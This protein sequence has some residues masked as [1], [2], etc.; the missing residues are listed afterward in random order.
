MAA[1]RFDAAGVPVAQV[2]R[3]PSLITDDRLRR[4]VEECLAQDKDYSPHM[5]RVR[6]GL[7]AEY[8]FIL[9]QKLR[10]RRVYEATSVCAAPCV[11]D[12]APLFGRALSGL[13]SISS[14]SS[15]RLHIGWRGV[16][17]SFTRLHKAFCVFACDRCVCGS[18]GVLVNKN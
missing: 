14:I 7:G 15:C 11:V 8:E 3:S 1:V 16:R 4:E 9:Q 10:A 13:T 17:V 2:M 18:G 6:R 5:D 12:T